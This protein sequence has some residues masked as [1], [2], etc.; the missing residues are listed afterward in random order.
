MKFN[1]TKDI[2]LKGIQSTQNAI[3][4]KS[5]LPILSNILI[6]AENDNTILTAT[7]LDIGITTTVPIKPSI[8]GSVTIPAKK[9][10]DIIKELPESEISI[11]VKKNNLVNIE[12]DTCAFKIMGLPKDEFPQLPEFKDRDSII[13]PQ[14]KLKQMLGMTSFAMSRDESRYVLNGVL[15]IIKSSCIRLVA[16]DGRRLAVAEYKMQLPKAQERKVIAPTKTINELVRTL[17]DA[18]DVKISFGENQASFTIGSTRIISRLIEGEFPNYEAVVPKEAKEKM[19]VPKERFLSALKRVALF[20]NQESMAVKMDLTR[21]KLVLSKSTRDIGE[22][23]EELNVDYKGKD[24]SIGFNPDYI[25]DVLKAIDSETVGFEVIDSEK[26][27]VV[28]YGDDYVYV[29]LPMQI[30]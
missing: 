3:N 23:R 8:T 11:F 9:F 24:I 25:I 4:T 14:K 1:T 5:S 22:V 29:V 18:G 30:V 2:L 20:T 17:G 21:D 7:D 10:F 15:F 13:L 19:V 12:C 26:P 27:G 28:R 6:E 16:T